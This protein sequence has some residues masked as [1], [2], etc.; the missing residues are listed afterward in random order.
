MGS[1]RSLI[2]AR[3]VLDKCHPRH[4]GNKARLAQLPSQKGGK[5]KLRIINANFGTVSADVKFV[6]NKFCLMF[7]DNNLRDNIQ[8]RFL[9]ISEGFSLNE[10]PTF[11]EEFLVLHD[12]S[13]AR[14]WRSNEHP[15]SAWPRSNFGNF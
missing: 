7:S 6:S 1:E 10:H 3:S 12:H 13:V 5:F 9:L 15:T 14:G 8:K 2:G 4:N 11:S